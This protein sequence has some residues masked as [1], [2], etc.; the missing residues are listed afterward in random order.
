MDVKQPYLDAGV[1]LD[2]FPDFRQSSGGGPAFPCY[3]TFDA[4]VE[5]TNT[6]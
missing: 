4:T 1:E 6:S 5:K 3:I 2:V